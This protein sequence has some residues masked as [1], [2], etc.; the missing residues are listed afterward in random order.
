MLK[1]EKR[2]EEKINKNVASLN[3]SLNS[4]SFSSSIKDNIN[5]IKKVFV[6]NDLLI[7]REVDNS[8]DNNLH[9]AIAYCNGL[10]NASIINENIIKPLILSKAVNVDNL[11]LDILVKSVILIDEVKKT[12]KMKDVVENITY[13]D[14]ILIVD[15]ISEFLILN[16]KL[17]EKRTITEPENEKVLGGPREGF[18]EALLTNL[19]LISRKLRTN[20]LKLK[21]ITLGDKTNTEG[22][23]CYIDSI[24][25]K[26]VLEEFKKRI[27]KIKIDGV[28]DTNYIVELTRD[29]PYSPFRTTNYTERPDT[30]VGK[31]LEGRIAFIL[32]GTPMVMTVP[33]LF[34]EN[35]QNSED[36][37]F[38]YFY[39]S[40]SRM[41]RI[42][43]F[44]L[45]VTV[46]AFYIAIVVYHKEMLPTQLFINVAIERQNVP[47]PAAIEAFIMLIVFDI[48]KETGIRMPSN[49]GQA[50]SIV[51]AIV[52]GQALVEAKLI[53]APMIIVVAFT[54]ITSLL[55]PRL[56]SPVVYIRFMLLFL[57]SVLG[58]YGL[59]IGLSILIIHIFNLNSFGVSQTP[60]MGEFKFQNIKDIIFRAPWWTMVKRP[61]SLTN[62]VTR[63]TQQGV[64][65]NE[66][67]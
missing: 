17:L 6:D 30:V 53:A 7:V 41:I 27:G 2:K 29:N 47:L 13:G 42:L 31:L 1:N 45:T 55:V 48:I 52:I 40:F 34:V 24:V 3:K 32:D 44:F 63:L 22:C 39:T 8:N 25:D 10:V 4:I 36:Y 49:I 18:T 9:Y 61:K 57:A 59:I 64:N 23:I 62:N 60:E 51:G 67:Y 38:S 65:T 33:Y 66:N 58:L 5:I 16:T 54:G 11:N 50:L 20:D 15:G 28:L 37:Y 21:Y 12:N 19:S 46:P 26:K 56:N 14:V 35:F 43:G